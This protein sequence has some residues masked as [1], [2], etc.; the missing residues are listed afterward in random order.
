MAT[1][2]KRKCRPYAK[3]SLAYGFFPSQHDCK[4]SMCLTC[5]ATLKNDSMRPSKLH[6]ETIHQDKWMNH[7]SISKIYVRISIIETLLII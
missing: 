1:A 3:Y 5:L 6:L 4:I 7:L 2:P